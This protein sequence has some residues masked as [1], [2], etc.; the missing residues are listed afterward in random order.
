MFRPIPIA[1]GVIVESLYQHASFNVRDADIA[2]GGKDILFEGAPDI[3][4]IVTR[5]PQHS[6]NIK[7]PQ[8]LRHAL[9]ESEFFT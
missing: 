5:S 8:G 3:L 4:G 9:G 6:T 1:G 7:S 2:D